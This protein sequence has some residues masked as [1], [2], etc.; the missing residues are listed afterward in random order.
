M[1]RAAPRRTPVRYTPVTLPRSRSGNQLAQARDD[2]GNVIACPAPVG[3]RKP[4]RD[5]MPTPN[6]VNV[7]ANDQ[8]INPSEYARLTPKQSTMQ[9]AATFVDAETATNDK[10]RTPIHA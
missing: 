3:M 10:I 7:E 9:P 1:T 4:S 6:P 2:A 5:A 8:K